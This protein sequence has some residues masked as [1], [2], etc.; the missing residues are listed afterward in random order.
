MRVQV[1]DLF[2]SLGLRVCWIKHHKARW[3]RAWPVWFWHIKQGRNDGGFL[4]LLY[5]NWTRARCG[6][7]LCIDSRD[8]LRF[9]SEIRRACRYV[10]LLS[11]FSGS[12]NVMY[13]R[14]AAFGRNW[15]WRSVTF[16][17]TNIHAVRRVRAPSV[18]SRR[19]IVRR[20]SN[21]L[22]RLIFGPRTVSADIPNLVFSWRASLVRYSWK[23]WFVEHSRR[24]PI[25]TIV[26][27]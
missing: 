10:T 20:K 9:S 4:L 13:R 1:T 26:T 2:H 22:V 18:T 27:F 21:W 23:W 24:S 11:F 15:A 16:N 19:P 8:I 5:R 14:C 7:G 6:R 25:G 12:A 17:S 3:N